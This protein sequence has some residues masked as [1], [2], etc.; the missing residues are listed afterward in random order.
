[1]MNKILPILIVLLFGFTAAAFAQSPA[2]IVEY[3]ENASGE[4]YV[5]TP[6]GAEYDV[7]QFGFGEQLPVG[8]TLITLDG[9]YAELR[10]D[11]NGTIIRVGENTNFR[12]DALQG[13]SGAQQN[14]F[15]VAVGKFKAV[16][17]KRDGTRYSFHGST[18][19][20]G[21]RG[22]T[23]IGSIVP[24]VEEIAY[25]LDGVVEYTN[26][27]GRTITLGAGEAANALAANFVKFQ[28][29]A[30]VRQSLER[31]MDFVRLRANQVPGYIEEVEEVIEEAVEEA[32]EP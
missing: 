17:A 8:T 3:Y 31:G 27:A 26:A 24:G 9:D 13:C 25:I 4:M 20:M 5:R 7:D 18:A 1:M 2:V 6:D 23:L 22:T 29:S 32:E 21:V 14:T 30:G 19:V 28:P 15:N 16:V 11:P 12:I 10:M